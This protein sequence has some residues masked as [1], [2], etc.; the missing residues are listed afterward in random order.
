[1]GFIPNQTNK[2]KTKIYSILSKINI[3]NYLKFQLPFMHRQFSKKLSHK[4][5]HNQ[6]HCKTE[7]ILSFRMSKVIFI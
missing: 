4:P 1:M 3:Q 5:E 7:I 2:F 6:T